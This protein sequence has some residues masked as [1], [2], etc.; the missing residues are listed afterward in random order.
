VSVSTVTAKGKANR[1]TE[2]HTVFSPP[3]LPADV[4][5]SRFA[6]SLSDLANRYWIFASVGILLLASAVRLYA[7]TLKPMHHDEGVNGFFMT[8]LVR[9]GIYLYDPSNYHGP[10]LYYLALPLVSVFGLDIFALRLITVL[11][12]LLTIVLILDLR[13]YLGAEAT[14]LAA[15]LLAVSPGAVFYSRY[16]IHEALFVLFTVGIVVSA[17]RFYESRRIGF[18]I[19]G[20][21]SAGLLFATKE[22]AFV[23]LITLCL[24]WFVA[25][26]WTSGKLNADKLMHSIFRFPIPEARRKA[27]QERAR[28][29]KKQSPDLQ[30]IVA[31]LGGKDR[32]TLL[33]VYGV[34]LF[35]VVNVLFYS[36]F[37][38][39]WPGV[40]GA[41]ES[42]KIWTNTGTSQ[43]HGKPFGTYITWL[44]QE[45]MP[46]LLL[47]LAGTWVAL[48]ATPV[49]RFAVFV[50]A[51]AFGILVA[52]SLIPY[53]TPW[54]MLSFVV[55]MALV[56]GY[57][58]QSLKNRSWGKLKAPLPALVVFCGALVIS[59]Y[60]TFVLNYREF[61]NDQYPY[62]YAHTNRELTALVSDVERIAQKAGTKDIGISIASP[63]NWPLPWYFRDFPKAG[64]VGSVSDRYDPNDIPIV[65]GRE[66]AT[67]EEDQTQKLLKVLGSTYGK[68]GSYTLRPGVRLALFARQ[69]LT[70]R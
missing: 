5:P 25:Y 42:L 16:F 60:Q 58:I 24:A 34:G 70:L 33:C 31:E 7:L 55:P 11:A 21:V 56:G 23:S 52:Y 20:A 22:T 45:E 43:F 35:L 4:T 41:V 1:K 50:A 29:A 65:I 46:L 18:L 27:A 9:Q 28:E 62:V 47:A 51:W 15:L 17:L 38:T 19:L 49:N 3:V 2:A 53:K 8:R 61:D 6:T 44:L 68:V 63:E 40:N 32:V 39:N 26:L 67:P 59:G 66:S 57:A 69:D 30:T 13:R 54:L 36:S 64:Y 48:F 10:T 14:L 12:G 37:F